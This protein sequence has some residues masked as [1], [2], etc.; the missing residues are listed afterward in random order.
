[1]RSSGGGIGFTLRD[2]FIDRSWGLSCMAS[3]IL[4]KRLLMI[5]FQWI[6][7]NFVFFQYFLLELSAESLAF[8][9]FIMSRHKF[10]IE[11]R[12]SLTKKYC[13]L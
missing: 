6:F 8:L 3:S 13:F 7:T 2:D 11:M 4:S 12:S 9:E 10:S 5:V 1:L